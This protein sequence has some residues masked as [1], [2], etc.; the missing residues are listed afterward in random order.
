MLETFLERQTQQEMAGSTG[1]TARRKAETGTNSKIDPEFFLDRKALGHAPPAMEAAE[2]NEARED[3]RG[4]RQDTSGE[5]RPKNPKSV[6]RA[7][8]TNHTSS[9][10]TTIHSES[11]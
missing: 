11:E 2:R 3:T 5:T 8:S 9:A 1:T 6:C 4:E 7:I 10:K